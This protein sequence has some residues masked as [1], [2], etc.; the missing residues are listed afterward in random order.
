MVTRLSDDGSEQPVHD[1]HERRPLHRVSSKPMSNGGIVTTHQDITEQRRSEAKI[2]HMALHDAL[3]GL[4]NRVLFNERLDQALT[5]AK[6]GE[7]VA[8][9]S[10]STSTTSRTSTIRSAIPPATSCCK[11]RGRP[12][13]HSGARHRH[14]RAHGRRRVRHCA[15]GDPGAGRCRRRWRTGSSTSLSEPYEIDGHQVVIGTSV[16]I[17][18]G[19]TDGFDARPVDPQCRPGALS[20]PR[21]TAAALS[22][23]SSRTWMRRCKSGAPWNKTCARRWPPANSSSTTSP[24]SISPATRSAASRR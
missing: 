18:V 19:P 20:A 12:P 1:A 11:C 5:R 3:T 10:C 14:H 16:G 17:A 4:P 21:A 24:S 8:D 22:A 6:R 23:S 9:P 2:V 7:I 13:A 15:G